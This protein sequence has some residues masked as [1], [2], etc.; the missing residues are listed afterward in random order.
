MEKI[1]IVDTINGVAVDLAVLFLAVNVLLFSF[2]LN[3]LNQPFRYLYYFLI[4]NL[5][6]EV[7]AFIFIESK[8]N[9]L[10]LLHLYTL[11]EFILASF[12][13]RSLQFKHSIFSRYFWYIIIIGSSLII[14]NSLF[15]QSISG[16]NSTARTGVQMVIIAYAVIYFYNLVAD[17]HFAQLKSKS[18]RLVNSAIIIYY[19]GSLFIFMFSQISFANQ[20]IYKLFWIFNAFLY[21]T[22]HLIIFTALWIAF[23]RNTPS[24]R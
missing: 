4:F 15:F 11:G 23:Y 2:K 8:I 3:Q 16:F 6:I 9:N 19:S 24:S 5:L 12:F 10:P 21:V 7:S 14:A 13:Y 1:S 18:M 22:Y 20:D 17:E